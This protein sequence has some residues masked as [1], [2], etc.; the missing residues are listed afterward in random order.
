MLSVKNVVTVATIAPY[1]TPTNIPAENALSFLRALI[2]S[3]AFR[4]A[5]GPVLKGRDYSVGSPDKVVSVCHSDP[6]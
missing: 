6:V 1:T 2:I 4:L 5:V 3:L